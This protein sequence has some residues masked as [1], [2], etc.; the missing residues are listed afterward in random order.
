M[1]DRRTSGWE[2]MANHRNRTESTGCVD[3]S[4]IDVSRSDTSLKAI[5]RLLAQNAARAAFEAHKLK[6]D[7]AD[8]EPK[9]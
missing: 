1:T 5:A 8:N 2:Q 4:S 3:T 6:K 9:K 7:E